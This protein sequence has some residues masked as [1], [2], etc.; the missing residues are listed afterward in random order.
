MRAYEKLD[1]FD[2]AVVSAQ[3]RRFLVYA[4]AQRLAL[5]PSK[6]PPAPPHVKDYNV[7]PNMIVAHL[8]KHKKANNKEL[9]QATG[10]GKASIK[11]ATAA[12]I[13][14]GELIEK[15]IS[16]KNHFFYLP[17]VKEAP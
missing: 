2:K 5:L 10:R 4:V 15:V 8:R 17:A 13:K 6:P 7:I 1:R 14:R 3:A 9:A 16:R 12:M 11:Y